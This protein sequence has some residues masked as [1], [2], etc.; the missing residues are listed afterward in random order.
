AIECPADII[1]AIGGW[2]TEGIGHQYGKGH[3]LELKFRWS[4]KMVSESG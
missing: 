1:D 2:T 3:S 4:E